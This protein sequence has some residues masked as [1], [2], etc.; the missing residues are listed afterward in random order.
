MTTECAT[1]GTQI[2]TIGGRKKWYNDGR[3]GTYTMPA[4]I[5]D[6]DSQAIRS[7]FDVRNLLNI[8]QI[9]LRWL[10]GR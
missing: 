6:A 9:S 1:Y 10:Q 3:A 7:N 8:Y 2:F 5:Y 4:F